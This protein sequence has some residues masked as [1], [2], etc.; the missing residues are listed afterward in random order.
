[1]VGY[2]TIMLIGDSVGGPYGQALRNSQSVLSAW[3]HAAL[4]AGDYQSKGRRIAHCGANPAAGIKP[5]DPCNT[6]SSVGC[7]VMGE[8]SAVTVCGHSDDNIFNQS[9]IPPASCLTIYWWWNN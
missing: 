9:S 7:L 8:P 3:S 4:T 2:R 5:G 1:V 6:S